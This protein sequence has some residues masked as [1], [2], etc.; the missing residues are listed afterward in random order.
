MGVCVADVELM[1]GLCESTGDKTPPGR[2][3]GLAEVDVD[4]GQHF[5][6]VPRLGFSKISIFV[7][8]QIKEIHGSAQGWPGQCTFTLSDE[9]GETAFGHLGPLINDIDVVL[10][11]PPSPTADRA[12]Y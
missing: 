2:V 4:G 1:S 12:N 7:G 5:L 11:V 9:E 6:G 10:P 8:N 3:N